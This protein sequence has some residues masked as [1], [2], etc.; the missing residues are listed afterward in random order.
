MASL[1]GEHTDAF[2]N[3]SD[4]VTNSRSTILNFSKMVGTRMKVAS[5]AVSKKWKEVPTVL[6]V[7]GVGGV[8]AVAAPLAIIPTLGVIGFTSAGVAAGSIAASIQ[9]ATTVSGSIFALCQS[10]GAVGAV[11]A[12]TSVAVGLTA[13]AAGGGLTAALCRNKSNNEGSDGN[14]PDQEHKSDESVQSE[15]EKT[16]VNDDEQVK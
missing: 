10:A 12:S 7:V 6:K 9:T 5:Q 13:G 4:Q 15:T 16:I 1:S 2:S 11:A 3:V 14:V 8:C